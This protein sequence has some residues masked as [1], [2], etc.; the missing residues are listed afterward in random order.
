MLASDADRDRFLGLLREAYAAGRITIDELRDAERAAERNRKLIGMSD[1]LVAFWDGSSEGTRKTIE[2]A[3][4]AGK[5][6]HVF[7]PR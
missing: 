4:E 7:L 5:E 1:V 6:L 2:R 3:L